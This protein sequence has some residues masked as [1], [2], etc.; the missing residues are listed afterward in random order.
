MLHRPPD[1]VH[2]R[3]LWDRSRRGSRHLPSSVVARFGRASSDHLVATET[4]GRGTSA[5]NR[6]TQVPC[7]GGKR[8]RPHLPEVISSGW[9]GE[10]LRPNLSDGCGDPCYPSLTRLCWSC[11]YKSPTKGPTV[12]R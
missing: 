4:V 5:T 1:S 10:L 2:L 3:C 11:A 6:R 12:S 7:W 8:S 9:N